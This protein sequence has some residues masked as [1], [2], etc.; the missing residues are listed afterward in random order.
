MLI[1]GNASEQ[2]RLRR[3]LDGL[4]AIPARIVHTIYHGHEVLIQLA[5]EAPDQPTSLQTLVSSSTLP[6]LGERDWL[7]VTDAVVAYPIHEA[8]QLE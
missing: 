4:P 2:P 8:L 7:T 6:E 1:T 3:T 5:V